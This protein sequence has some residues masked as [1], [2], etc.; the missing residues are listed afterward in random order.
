[1]EPNRSSSSGHARVQ[2][3]S[4]KNLVDTLPP[5]NAY[6]TPQ[7]AP[8]FTPLSQHRTTD[9]V[10]GFRTRPLHASPAPPSRSVPA[11]A[12]TSTASYGRTRGEQE[13][14]YQTSTNDVIQARTSR[15]SMSGT[16]APIP[17]RI[18]QDPFNFR[19]SS[20]PSAAMLPSMEHRRYAEDSPAVSASQR[21]HGQ[22][23]SQ[24]SY[25][26]SSNPQ[27]RGFGDRPTS[28]LISPPDRDGVSHRSVQDLQSRAGRLYLKANSERVLP[29]RNEQE[30][31]EYDGPTP[32]TPLGRHP[33]GAMADWDQSNTQ[34]SRYREGYDAS[35]VDHTW[36]RPD[37]VDRSQHLQRRQEPINYQERRV[38]PYPSRSHYNL[39]PGRWE[40]ENIPVHRNDIRNRGNPSNPYAPSVPIDTS[41]RLGREVGTGQNPSRPIL[42]NEGWGSSHSS[43]RSSG[44][45]LDHSE[46]ENYIPRSAEQLHRQPRKENGGDEWPYFYN[47]VA[48]SVMPSGH[49]PAPIKAMVRHRSKEDFP[50][51][52]SE[53][54]NEARDATAGGTAM[55]KVRLISFLPRLSD[56]IHHQ[57]HE[58]SNT[59]ANFG[60][61]GPFKYP[62]H[63]WILSI[64]QLNNNP[65]DQLSK[66]CKRCLFA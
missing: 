34:P 44:R 13:L 5:P 45:R 31:D 3:P 11:A 23:Q 12:V 38:D 21:T 53:L 58:F 55:K 61:Y 64:P 43:D 4:I 41:S 40:R 8:G 59:V 22:R 37:S 52:L 20:P 39:E 10:G 27:S 15:M 26:L 65:P 63:L 56:S 35:T 42:E 29:L 66:I 24:G 48:T 14:P 33:H 62:L 32:T 28:A 51:V 25:G 16:T 57:I 49:R 17:M 47:G 19:S 30:F 46:Q 60:L 50:R 36:Y 54:T 2:L 18:N 9:D 7:V 1:M 6:R